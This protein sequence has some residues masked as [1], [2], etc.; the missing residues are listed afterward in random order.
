MP[1]ASAAW[2][3]PG[4]YIAIVGTVLWT[5]GYAVDIA[6]ATAVSNWL[7]A[8]A[9]S[10]AAA[11]A[12]VTG[13]TAVSRGSFPTAVV[14]DWLA[15]AFLSFGMLRSAVYPRWL[16]W[17]GLVFGVAGILLGIVQVFSGR[18]G[19]FNLF[20]VLFALTMLWLLATGIWVAR[21]AW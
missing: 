14:V 4:F 17:P 15:F 1:A 11:H 10:E 6:V 2:A 12:V 21:K 8:P 18:E 5:V 16:S 20:T 7:S 19:T 13:L 9:G 3:R